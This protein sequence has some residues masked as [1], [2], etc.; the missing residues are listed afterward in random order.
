MQFPNRATTSP[1]P[2]L[3]VMPG[4]SPA[5]EE[6]KVRAMPGQLRPTVTSEKAKGVLVVVLAILVIG[7]LIGGEVWLFLTKPDIA[8]IQNQIKGQVSSIDTINKNLSDQKG[9]LDSIDTTLKALPSKEEFATQK[10]TL[11]DL[12]KKLGLVDS[13][14]DLMPDVWETKY[15]LNPQDKRDALLD[16]D[17]D[18][19]INF[20]EYLLDTDPTNKDTDG[21]GYTDGAE[22]DHGFNPK[23]SGKLDEVLKVQLTELQA[24]TTSSSTTGTTQTETTQTAVKDTDKDGM[25]DDWE[26]KYSLNPNDPADATTDLDK[27]GLSNLDEYKF[28]SD[29][30]KADTDGDGY[31]DGQEVSSGYNPAGT[32]KLADLEKLTESAK[33]IETKAQEAAQPILQQAQTE[34]TKTAEEVAAESTTEAT[35]AA[36]E[37]AEVLVRVGLF[38]TSRVAKNYEA[39]L[40]YMTA[41]AEKTYKAEVITG[42]SD[43]TWKPEVLDTQAEKKGN[44]YIIKVK[45]SE[46]SGGILKGTLVDSFTETQTWIKQNDNWLL[47]KIEGNIYQK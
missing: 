19:L 27:D 47:D 3:R 10:A 26:T 29:P 14:H 32:G 46:Y 16:K 4:V 17:Q 31:S 39:S 1:M 43:L 22:V 30:T 2:G 5:R 45:I 20:D 9:R 42:K 23:G 15:G 7:G 44:D 8:G 36:K 6:Y 13:D 33:T 35:N 38:M 24:S 37:K 40:E 18:G 34:A 25:P 21:D 11:D 12:N 41:N 28:G